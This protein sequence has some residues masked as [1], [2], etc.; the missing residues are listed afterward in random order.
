MF[1]LYSLFIQRKTNPKS[2]PSKLAVGRFKTQDTELSLNVKH[3]SV[4]VRYMYVKL[5]MAETP[6]IF[7]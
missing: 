6:L 5:S 2:G 7:Y 4:N 3:M 1:R